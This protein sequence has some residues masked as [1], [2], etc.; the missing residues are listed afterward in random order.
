MFEFDESEFNK[1]ELDEWLNPR[2]DHIV[3]N[4]SEKRMGERPKWLIKLHSRI[5]L[6]A[7]YALI[8]KYGYV[9]NNADFGDVLT[10]KPALVPQEIKSRKNP[11]AEL[12]NVIEDMNQ[13]KQWYPDTTPDEILY[14]GRKDKYYWLHSFLIWNEDKKTYVQDSINNV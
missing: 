12:Q 5:G 11:D 14:F 2:I 13:K 9:E 1:I 6:I 7:E 4:L 10:P 3:N 8:K